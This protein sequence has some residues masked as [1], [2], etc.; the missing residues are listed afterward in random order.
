MK[1]NAYEAMY[2]ISMTVLLTCDV[3]R[4]ETD[5]NE[6]KE[7]NCKPMARFV[8]ADLRPVNRRI[9]RE[10]ALNSYIQKL[11]EPAFSTFVS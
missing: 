1:Y 3:L 5:G 10:R 6:K 7:R 11:S 9:E 2:L 4:V 8:Q